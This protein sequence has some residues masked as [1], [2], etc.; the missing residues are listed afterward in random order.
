MEETLPPDTHA[1]TSSVP[2]HEHK[3]D[4]LH[5]V[6]VFWL[7]RCV[8]PEVVV[9]TSLLEYHGCFL[10]YPYEQMLKLIN[11]SDLPACYGLLFQV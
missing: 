7:H 11:S 1:H 8:V 5:V 9:E 10:G 2:T 4:Q 3:N 6:D